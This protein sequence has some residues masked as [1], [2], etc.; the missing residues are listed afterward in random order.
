MNG[1]RDDQ[2]H[3]LARLGYASRLVG[4]F[5]V[6]AAMTCCAG[7][8]SG[9]GAPANVAVFFYGILWGPAA[10]ALGC[11]LSLFAPDTKATSPMPTA[12]PA[13]VAPL[14]ATGSLIVGGMLSAV[15]CGLM[16]SRVL[17]ASYFSYMEFAFAAMVAL[18]SAGFI[19]KGLRS[20]GR[21]LLGP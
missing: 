12:L 16:Y 8:V 1:D 4:A 21:R 10:F 9:N 5:L 15:A 20:R 14:D 17:M 13:P 18:I 2:R 19:R 7:F 6:L 3:V 11:I